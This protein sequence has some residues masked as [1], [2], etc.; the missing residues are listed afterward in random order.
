MFVLKN[1]HAPELS[2]AN[3]YATLSRSKQLLTNIHRHFSLT[4]TFTLATPKDLQNDR[5]YLYA[6]PSTKKKEVATK[7][8]QAQLTFSLD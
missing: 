4:K 1:R 2:E 8:L 7:R 5:L 3:S 6:R